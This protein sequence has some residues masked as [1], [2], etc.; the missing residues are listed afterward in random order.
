MH[1]HMEGP[2]PR[3]QSDRP[4]DPPGRS[5][6]TVA[7]GGA[8]RAAEGPEGWYV[9]PLR[10]AKRQRE[11]AV[12][13]AKLT[14]AACTTAAIAILVGVVLSVAPSVGADSSSSPTGST[15]SGTSASPN[16]LAPGGVAR[17]LR[18]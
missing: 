10:E 12:R 7:R 16:A 17:L 14:V 5:S 8:H 11:R 13:R 2:T 9:S 3:R 1:P 18:P 6:V 4:T 15:T